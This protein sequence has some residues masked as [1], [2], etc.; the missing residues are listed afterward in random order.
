MAA[1]AG[2]YALTGTC[3]F[4]ATST[5]P[6]HAAKLAGLGDERAIVA[7]SKHATIDHVWCEVLPRGKREDGQPILHG[8]DVILDG[9]CQEKLAVLREDSHFARLGQD[10]NGDH[11]SHAH[12]LDHRSGAKAW[13]NVEMFKAQ[14]DGSRALRFVFHD[15]LENLVAEGVEVE[16]KCL[17]DAQSVFHEDFREAAI[18]ALHKDDGKPAPG[19]YGF[20][21]GVDPL[22]NR[23]KRAAVPEIQAV[24]VARSLGADIR[25]AVAEAP[26]IIASAREMFPRPESKNEGFLARIS[27]FFQ[28]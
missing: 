16:E 18:A 25:G 22:A 4:Y 17:W 24:G 26:R 2:Q 15:Q 11:L 1:A 21:P 28:H 27:A 20:I 5:A 10:G 7:Q 3:F 6:L 19:M 13:E 9:W 23:A 14:I 8:E 12:L